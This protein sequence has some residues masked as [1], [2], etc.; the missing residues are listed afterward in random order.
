MGSP[1]NQTSVN[2]GTSAKIYLHVIKSLI[3]KKEKNYETEES[4]LK[5][6]GGW[7]FEASLIS[8]KG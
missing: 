6:L 2:F 3:L 1:C 5:L 4:L 8:L 7:L